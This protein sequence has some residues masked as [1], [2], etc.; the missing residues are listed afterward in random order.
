V[1]LRNAALLADTTQVP[2]TPASVNHDVVKTTA[3][4]SLSRGRIF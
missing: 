2:E 3:P 1:K 4:P